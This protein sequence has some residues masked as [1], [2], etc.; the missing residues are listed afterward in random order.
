MAQRRM[1]AVAASRDRCADARVANFPALNGRNCLC[2]VLPQRSSGLYTPHQR[3]PSLAV[4]SK[5]QG[6]Q[7]GDIIA[8][9]GGGGGARGSLVDRLSSFFS[10]TD[11]G[12]DRRIAGA[13]TFRRQSSSIPRP[14]RVGKLCRR[15][16][17]PMVSHSRTFTTACVL[18]DWLTCRRALE[19][20]HGG[21]GRRSEA[22]PARDVDEILNEVQPNVRRL[23]RMPH[24]DTYRNRCSAQ[25]LRMLPTVLSHKPSGRHQRRPRPQHPG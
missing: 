18:R 4:V 12:V 14:G 17:S 25:A 3:Q 10:R 22:T 1:I 13:E 19:L 21:T 6:R 9:T 16:E 23:D 8:S 20:E 7:D 2:P 11:D 5:S 15:C 24:G